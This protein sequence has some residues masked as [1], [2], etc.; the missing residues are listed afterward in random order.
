MPTT[1]KHD[2]IAQILLQAAAMIGDRDT[3]QKTGTRKRVRKTPV[4]KPSMAIKPNLAIKSRTSTK[5]ST[6]KRSYRPRKIQRTLAPGPVP[7]KAGAVELGAWV[8]SLEVGALAV[9][10]H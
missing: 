6:G 2:E 3:K 10:V 9:P 8:R 4:R 7:R 1:A 5:I